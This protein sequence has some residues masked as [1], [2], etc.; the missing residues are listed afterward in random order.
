MRD[1][2]KEA[3]A[4]M[5]DTEKEAEAEAESR[6]HAGSLMWDSIPRHWDNDLS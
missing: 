2:E 6:I 5:K 3:E 4:F 1:T